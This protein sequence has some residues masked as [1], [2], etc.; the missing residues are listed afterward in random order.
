M[1]IAEQLNTTEDALISFINTLR[2]EGIVRRIGGV[3]DARRL[4]Y[5]SCL[6]GVHTTPNTL[7]D[8][9]AA[10]IAHP[11]VTH[12]YLRGWPGTFQADNISIT[13][14]AT[15][16]NFWYT[17]SAPA[18]AFQEAAAPLQQFAPIPFPALT[19]YKIDVVFDLRTRNRD[20][21]T[22]YLS[23]KHLSTPPVITAEQKDIVRR[24][25]EDTLAIQTPFR[26]ED[27]PQLRLW[28]ADGTLRRFGLLLYHRASGFSAN[29]MCCWDVS[30][31]E[32]DLYG[33]RLAA[34]PD[35]T[36][37]YARPQHEHFPFSLYAMIHKT[38]W[39]AALDTFH[40]LSQETGLHHH[41]RKIFFSTQEY[42]KSSLR[43]FL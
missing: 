25:Q 17:L 27:L 39:Q 33:R 28:L 34:S 10:T 5:R 43:F 24:Y 16:P 8:I 12:A 14:Y 21:K 29:G 6:F 23:P 35:V 38:S 7:S 31:E 15:Y 22:E 40:R 11:G 30:P 42:K 36:H 9:V 37:C 4:G 41:P 3:F 20:E 26:A 1:V 32:I 13:D 2:Q 18:D 19:R